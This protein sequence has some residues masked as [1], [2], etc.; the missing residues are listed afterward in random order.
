MN[1]IISM[2]GIKYIPYTDQKE[3]RVVDRKN[4][5]TSPFDKQPVSSLSYAADGPQSGP[6]SAGKLR[7]R[8]T[9]E[10]GVGSD[11]KQTWTHRECVSECNFVK[12]SIRYL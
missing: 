8:V 9:G 2:N 12:V 5:T 4:R 10:Q 11:D 3:N 1:F 6:Q 7:V